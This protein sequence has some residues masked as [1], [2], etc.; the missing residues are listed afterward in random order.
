MAN[1]NKGHLYEYM[2]EQHTLAVWVELLSLDSLGLNRAALYRRI[3]TNG[4][5]V[6]KA[7]TTPVLPRNRRNKPRLIEMDGKT[8]S[9][10]EW[11]KSLGISANIVYSRLDRGW[12]AEDALLTPPHH[13][14]ASAPLPVSKGNR[15]EYSGESHT[16]REWSEL[17]GIHLETLRGRMKNGWPLKRALEEPVISLKERWRKKREA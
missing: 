9:V 4:W 5:S 8:M 3:E 10:A 12:S 15:Y 13:Q 11:A 14:P 17:R 6:E 7:F 1:D 2:G 16:L